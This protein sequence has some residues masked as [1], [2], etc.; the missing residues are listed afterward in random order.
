MKLHIIITIAAL[1]AIGACNQQTPAKLNKTNAASIS[2]T[3]LQSPIGHIALPTQNWT[4]SGKTG[5][6]FVTTDG[7]HI[8][9]SPGSF[10]FADGS[11]ATGAIEISYKPLNDLAAIIASGIP[12]YAKNGDH[13]SPFISDG[14]F[15][16]R[17][18]CEGKTVDVAPGKSIQVFTLAH[19]TVSDFKYWH[20]NETTHSWD[21]IGE[22]NALIRENQ[23]A[24]AENNL[25]K[26]IAVAL[27]DHRSPFQLADYQNPTPIIPG[28]LNPKRTT[29][30]ID[31]NAQLYPELLKYKSLMWQYA[32][33][34][35]SDDPDQNKW[36]FNQQWLNIKLS[37]HATRAM[38][39]ELEILT[40][41]Q[42]FK[43]V[44]RPVV[45]G[46]DLQMAEQE[47]TQY[48]QQQIKETISQEGAS[49]MAIQEKIYNAFSILKLGMLN[50]D[51]FRN[52]IPNAANTPQFS[53]NN[54]P[55]QPD[56]VLTYLLK[57]GYVQLPNSA[58]IP[59]P[60]NM[61]RAIYTVSG[62]GTLAT[63]TKSSLTNYRK[64]PGEYNKLELKNIPIKIND[65]ES[66]K[67]ALE[68]Y[69]TL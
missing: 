47:Y 40:N 60:P 43:T 21:E 29:L 26:Q 18:S 69:K 67:T 7:S 66:L 13:I 5:G 45:A 61:I 22:R 28:K 55:I 9:V 42:I 65:L 6:K 51:R 33:D 27:Q 41:R 38:V 39:F 19:D 48:T 16:L 14:M 54:L 37:P 63:V 49:K 31:F 20:F 11:V 17:A 50:C 64:N 56:A 53:I 4:L 15:E 2:K 36:I 1:I 34:G 44:V 58:T 3:G 35:I 30:D 25:K 57:D 12:M 24:Q 52:A 59:F 8:L 32:G 68:K 23:L 10:V 62:Q 46:S